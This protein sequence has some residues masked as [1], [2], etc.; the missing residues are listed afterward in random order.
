[1][2]VCWM[3]DPRT[4]SAFELERWRQ[5]H[6]LHTLWGVAGVLTGSG[7]AAMTLFESLMKQIEAY[8]VLLLV[9]LAA[10]DLLCCCLAMRGRQALRLG[11]EAPQIG[12]E[13]SSQ[14]QLAAEIEWHFLLHL[15]N[16]RFDASQSL[17][18][19][20]QED[21]EGQPVEEVQCPICLDSFTQ[22]EEVTQPRCSH[23]FHRNCLEGWVETVSLQAAAHHRR[24]QVLCPLRCDSAKVRVWPSLSNAPSSLTGSSAYRG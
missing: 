15:I 7:I 16:Y 24:E 6:E 9:L 14:K 8:R 5:L 12:I 2:L 22:D 11:I 21:E 18:L 10:G 3:R 13:E 20:G 17:A 23:F 1:M 19:P 4:D